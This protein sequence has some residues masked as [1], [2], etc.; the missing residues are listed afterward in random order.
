MGQI[1]LFEGVDGAGK[2]VL[3][4]CL[5]EKI[6]ALYYPSPPEA[7][8]PLRALANASDPRARL[9]FYMFGNHLSSTEIAGYAENIDVVVDRYIYSTL[10]EHS[11]LLDDV[12]EMPPGLVQP[13]HII[14][15]T[16]SWQEIERRYVEQR[17]KRAER[18]NVA[19]QKKI[20]A[21]FDH[22]F[23]GLDN[24]LRVDTTERVP[25]DV[26]AE[27]IEAYSIKPLS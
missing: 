2:T 15:V 16:A 3:A 27:I 26:V 14:H 22:Y 19:H 23:S 6:S 20:A 7:I 21:M 25:E 24:V 9:N 10:T 17:P 1:Y 8:E 12:L 5:A 11:V 18:E 4:R 13:D